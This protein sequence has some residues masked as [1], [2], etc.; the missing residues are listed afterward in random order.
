M[1]LLTNHINCTATASLN[2]CTLYEL[3]QLLVHIKLFEVMYLELIASDKGML[4]PSLL[5]R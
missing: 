5:K 3:A 2:D 4:K 1:T